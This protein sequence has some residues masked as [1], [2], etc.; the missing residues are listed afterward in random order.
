[1]F[2]PRDASLLAVPR[3]SLEKTKET[4]IKSTLGVIAFFAM[5]TLFL[6][7]A[8]LI[9]EAIPLYQ[10]VSLGEFFFGTIWL[11]NSIPERFGAL[12][13]IIGT[14]WVTLGAMVVAIPLGIGCAIFIAFVA[15]KKLR[16]FMKSAIELLAGVPSVVF[17]FF[18]LQIILPWVRTTFDV[19]GQSW[20]AAS[21]LIGLISLPTVVSVSEDV[22]TSVGRDLWEA[23][24]G[25]GATKWE[26][27]SKII[28][29]SAISGIG[30]AVI[31]GI[32][33]AMG[34]TMAVMMV[35]GNSKLIPM[36]FFDLFRPI[37]TI[38]ATIG[39]EMGEA[40]LGS[41]HMYALYGLAL[42]LLFFM[43]FVNTVSSRVTSMLKKRMHGEIS[44]RNYF[45]PRVTRVIKV[46]IALVVVVLLLDLVA[47]NLGIG[48]ACAIVGTC[49]GAWLAWKFIPRAAVQYLAFGLVSMA[50]A[51]VLFFLGYIIYDIIFKGAPVVTW[52]FL[53]T[54]PRRGGREGGIM[55]AIVGTLY[56]V[57]G[58][59]LFAVPIGICTA[60]YLNEYS[61]D[62]GASGRI[63]KV[64][65]LG[66]DNLNGMPS[67]IFGL[68]GYTL[69]VITFG[70]G[71]SMLAGQLTLGL[72]VLPTVIRTTEESLR[73][74]PNGL[75][76]A[77]FALGATKWQ[78]VSK[79]V[80]PA[81][82]PGTI[83][84]IILSIGRASGETAPILFTAAIISSRFLPDSVLDPVMALPFQIYALTREFPDAVAQAYG[85]AFV[86]LV[87]VLAM[88]SLA[89]ILRNY[90]RKRIRL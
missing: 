58:A 52:E 23:S 2:S 63:K 55:P 33:R 56:L 30:V 32:G 39:L 19:P 34:E 7:I 35:A 3:L 21:L 88:Y 64:I 50:A 27:I 85:T 57:G 6:I 49:L 80:L 74:V 8:F 69:F 15:P 53:S 36:S 14:V 29:P 42:I 20:F 81:S 43:L 62:I 37:S 18:G 12:P 24:V 89:I 83:T 10:H 9:R 65:R 79:V 67:I 75:R 31:L 86:L 11:P 28:F 59:L 46:G 1:M 5:I 77:S 61:R 60:I 73:T 47:V 48:V 41:A 45:S 16:V 13:I 90:Y 51:I 44:R 70:L 38:T 22:L 84:G 4:A 17:G 54:F 71:R 40:P 26:T 87:L 82:T 78:T 66:V 76:E 25:V 68:F 72:M